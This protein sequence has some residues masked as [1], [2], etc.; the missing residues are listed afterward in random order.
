MTAM[1]YNRQTVWWIIIIPGHVAQNTLHI[2]WFTLRVFAKW[3]WKDR[4]WSRCVVGVSQVVP[5]LLPLISSSL[6]VRSWSVWRLWGW[7]INQPVRGDATS[8]RFVFSGSSG[9]QCAEILHGGFVLLFQSSHSPRYVCTTSTTSC[10]PIRTGP[11]DPLSVADV[12]SQHYE[13]PPVLNPLAH[14][15]F[16]PG[17]QGRPVFW[18]H[19]KWRR[20][21]GIVTLRCS[22]PGPRS[23]QGQRRETIFPPL[24]CA[25]TDSIWRHRA[26]DCVCVMKVWKSVGYR[27]GKKRKEK[28]N[29][30]WQSWKSAKIFPLKKYW[31]KNKTLSAPKLLSESR[32]NKCICHKN[33]KVLNQQQKN[34]SSE[35]N[36]SCNYQLF[37]T[38]TQW[39]RAL[40]LL[41]C[42]ASNTC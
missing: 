13:R 34:S 32:E 11:D 18:H 16:L 30:W 22:V 7:K 37:S 25:L 35:Q 40:T 41:A 3:P 9:R 2:M 27:Y 1:M 28:K 38:G 20:S 17:A 6:P 23:P 14:F 21:E 12:A 29:W 31:K 4:E 8:V 42:L 39:N 5:T 19:S 15:H 33:G 36:K 26:F 24:A 10:V